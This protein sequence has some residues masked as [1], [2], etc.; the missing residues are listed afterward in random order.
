MDIKEM[1]QQLAKAIKES[2][3]IT[4]YQKSKEELENHEAAKI[5]LKDL[6]AFQSLME[7][8]NSAGEE[9]STE[10]KDRFNRV[11]E[12]AQ[13]NPYVRDFLISEF[14]MFK[15]WEEVWKEISEAFNLDEK[16]QEIE[17]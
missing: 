8:K 2:K 15:L 1:T 17:P 4:E 13:M 16:G 12:M 5:M 6:K 10:D 9:I 11:Y 3:E 7:K 14:N